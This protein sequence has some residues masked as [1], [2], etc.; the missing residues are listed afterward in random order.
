[1]RPRILVVGCGSI[2]ARHAANLV[3]LDAAEVMLCDTDAARLA[4]LS[5]RHS[6]KGFESLEAALAVEPHAVLVCTPTHTHV[7]VALAAARA[8]CHLFVEK[9]LSHA[10]DGVAELRA[11]VR[12]HGLTALVACNM[13]FH[14]PVAR[15]QRLIEGGAVGRVL[16]VHSEFGHWLPNWRPE[17]DYRQAYSARAA[18][19]GGIVLDAIHELDYLMWFLGDVSAVYCVSARVSDLE[20]DTEDTAKL[21][22]RFKSGALGSVHL[23]YTQRFK[24][25]RC[26]VVGSEGTLIWES[27]GRAPER[28]TLECYSAASGQWRWIEEAV[29]VDPNTGYVEEMKH[30]LQCLDGRA[31][32]L[33]DIDQAGKVLRVTLAAKGSAE[34]G[35]EW[36]AP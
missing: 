21:V 27:R 16:S 15:L 17:A 22:L 1:M 7:P 18:E 20:I 10:L 32:P 11:L 2:G 31:A 35:R 12:R 19:G 5:S 6:L 4:T 33:Q 36:R 8:R 25:R 13:R 29:E 24:R 34:T 3:A 30:F 28:S 23:D 9:P 26:E 14:P